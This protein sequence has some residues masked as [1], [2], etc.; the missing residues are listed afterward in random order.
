MI[1]AD[2]TLREIVEFLDDYKKRGIPLSLCC[3]NLSSFE[4]RF[5][6]EMIFKVENIDATRYFDPLEDIDFDELILGL[7]QESLNI[8]KKKAFAV[9][10][11]ALKNEK[12]IKGLLEAPTESKAPEMNKG[13]EMVHGRILP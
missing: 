12:V 13:Q 4:S 7:G 10:I 3:Y 9:E 11:G 2:L 6:R 1:L 5:S 8:V